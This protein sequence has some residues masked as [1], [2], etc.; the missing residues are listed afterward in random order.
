[1]HFALD[2]DYAFCIFKGMSTVT[3][4]EPDNAL[5]AA[6]VKRGLSIADMARELGISRSQVSRMASGRQAIRPWVFR[7]LAAT[8]AAASPGASQPDHSVSP[9]AVPPAPTAAPSDPVSPSDGAAFSSEV[10]S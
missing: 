9:G 2:S 8:D 5:R 3:N 1:M 6:M 7:I 4:D 10:P